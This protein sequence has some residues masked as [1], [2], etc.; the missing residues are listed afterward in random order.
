MN[1]LLSDAARRAIR[2]LETLEDRPVFPRP[3][4][5]A[6]LPELGG[7]LPS[8]PCDPAAVLALLD[9]IASPATVASA[10]RRYFGFVVGGALPATVAASW[11]ATAWDQNAF[12][13]TMSPAVAAI[14]EVALGWLV[15]VLGL[16]LGT[17]GAFVT[18]A[19][20]AN[21]TALAAA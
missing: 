5:R 20:M 8:G 13:S 19:T 1:E 12:S 16:P 2:Y 14:E 7:P 6:R 18:G 3:D 15:D 17:A 4:S 11:L 9:E 10:G 21:L